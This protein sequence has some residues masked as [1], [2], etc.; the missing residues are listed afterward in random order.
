MSSNGVSMV[1]VGNNIVVTAF[2]AKPSRVMTRVLTFCG[3]GVIDLNFNEQCDSSSGC[4]TD[5]TC[6]KGTLAKNGLCL[7]GNEPQLDIIAD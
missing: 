4:S 6:V 3:N 5:C 2:D 1:Q 7:D